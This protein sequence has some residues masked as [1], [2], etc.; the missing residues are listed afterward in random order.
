M[1]KIGE[2][3]IV[4]KQFGIL[5]YYLKKGAVVDI[6]TEFIYVKFNDD[7]LSTEGEAAPTAG[8]YFTSLANAKEFLQLQLEGKIE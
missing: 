5:T 3:V 8:F 7:V 6:S 2:E 4:T 1:Y